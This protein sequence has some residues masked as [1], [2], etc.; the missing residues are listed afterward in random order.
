MIVTVEGG[1][2]R[3]RGLD[4]NLC[5]VLQPFGI[6]LGRRRSLAIG[7]QF[8]TLTESK[9]NKNVPMEMCQNA[10]ENPRFV[11]NVSL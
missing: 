10:T 8:L 7:R 11:Q 6:S 2:S 3:L 1:A 4:E 5:A 9:Q